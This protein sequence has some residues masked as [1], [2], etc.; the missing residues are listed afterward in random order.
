MVAIIVG[1]LCNLVYRVYMVKGLLWNAGHI[2]YEGAKFVI[3]VDITRLPVG[4]GVCSGFMDCTESPVMQRGKQI[5]EGVGHY[6]NRASG[7]YGNHIINITW[8]S[9]WATTALLTSVVVL[10]IDLI[11]CT[12]KTRNKGVITI[13]KDAH[14]LYLPPAFIVLYL[15]TLWKWTILINDLNGDFYDMIVF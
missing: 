11:S 9:L 10:S 2:C 6:G 8:S 13:I 5:A 14:L 7:R 12:W 1:S 3:L 4:S 15:K